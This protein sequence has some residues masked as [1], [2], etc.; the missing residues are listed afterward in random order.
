MDPR[1]RPHARNPPAR[2]DDHPP[3]DLL[4]QDCVGATDVARTF[5]RDGRRLETVSAFAQRG[6]GIHDDLVPGLSTPLEG[7][8]EVA[9]IDLE[10][11]AVRLE[12]PDGL[13]QQ[14]LASLVAVKD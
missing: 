12:Q 2:A 11:D 5:R 3:V 9:P 1:Q 8:V 6:G 4:A 7:E 14:L 13:P 10:T